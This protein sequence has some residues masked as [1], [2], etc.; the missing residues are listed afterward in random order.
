[1]G[2]WNT[3]AST[4]RVSIAVLLSASASVGTSWAETRKSAPTAS[5]SVA[6]VPQD[7]AVYIDGAL[8]G[9]TPLRIEEL[10]AGTHRVKIVKTGYL[11][12]SRFIT[13][14]PQRLTH[15]DVQLTRLSDA[16]QSAAPAAPAGGPRNKWLWIGAAGGAAAAVAVA[17]TKNGPP[18]GGSIVVTPAATGMAGQTSFTMV[19][20]GVRDPDNDRLSYAWNFGDGASGSGERVSHTSGAAG[21]FQVQLSISDGKHPVTAPSATVTVGA[22][23]SGTWTGG[24]VQMPDATGAITLNCG[25][26]LALTQSGSSLTGSMSFAGGCAGGPGAL[27]SGSANALTHPSG[28]AVASGLFSFPGGGAFSQGL[29]IIFSG[30]TSASGTALSGNVTLSNPSINFIR[31]TSTSFTK[32]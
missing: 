24:T 11:A 3:R 29:V 6:T 13:V 8:A 19:A 9:V 25:L 17:L 14:T 27:A 15:L 23:L 20:A 12:N 10:G 16:E 5:L 21:T 1:M 26:T 31:T 32:Q 2:P 22:N 28:V 30:T 7:A 4:A 18:V